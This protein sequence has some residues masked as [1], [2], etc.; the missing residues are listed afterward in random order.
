MNSLRIR[1]F[2]LLA[3]VTALVWASAATWIY[4]STR[5]EVERVLDRRLVEAARMVGSL[6]SANGSAPL[7]ASNAPSLPFRSYERQLSCQIWSLDGRLVGRSTGAPIEPLGPDGSG[8]SER[9]VE[10]E[11]WRV[12]SLVDRKRGIRVHVGD[13]VSV[14]RHLINDLIKG[15][16]LPALIGLL[17]LAALLWSGIGRGLL[18]LRAMARALEHR[19]TADLQ[20]LDM[21]HMTDELRPV[22]QSVNG[23][24][25]RLERVRASERHLVASAAHELQTP[26]AGLKTH[27]Q[28]AAMS[29]DPAVRS[30][31][32]A[33][34]QISVDRTARLVRQLLDLAR[35]E[36]LAEPGTAWAS[37]RLAA[38]IVRDELAL[39]LEARRISVVIEQDVDGLELALPESGLILVLR[40]LVENAVNHSMGGETVRITL[41]RRA[42]RLG[43]V[44]VDQG[45]GI[46]EEELLAVR[47]RFVRGRGEKGPGSG[48]GLSIVEMV[49]VRAGGILE[50]SNP[51][52]GGLRASVL[53]PLS[54]AHQ[55]F[56]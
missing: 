49:L 37:V 41:D 54:A 45:P 51:A 17:A 35:Q 38:A 55:K 1:L 18:P 50:L 4:F 20:A 9:R 16:L 23:L 13:N 2:A 47:D 24:F 52:E 39:S 36:A 19:D 28:I 5:A 31:A 8:F 56:H 32:L 27:A 22:A 3:A 34:I 21:R 48:L 43:F 15:L 12:Y 25:E 33:Q 42:D 53:L 46:P 10:G 7:T 30:R 40:N 44:V 26:L 6:T 11:T 14:R 29:D